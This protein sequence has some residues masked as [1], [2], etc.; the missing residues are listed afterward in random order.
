MPDTPTWIAADGTEHTLDGTN[1][2]K[3]LRGVEGR[4]MPPMTT[5]SDTVAGL[6]GERVRM[7]RAEPRDVAVPAVVSGANWLDRVRTLASLFDPRRGDGVLRWGDRQL[8][9]RY[10]DG[11][12]LDEGEGVPGERQ[13]MVLVF[14]AHDP[15]WLDAAP[16]V[17]LVDVD[18]LAF[19]SADD[20]DPWF[21]W[22]IVAS[23]AAG[24]FTVVNDGDDDAWPVWTVQGPGA[25]MLRLTNDATG[26]LL[27]LTGM[28]L[29]GGEKLIIDTRPGAKTVRGPAGENLWPDMTDDSTLWPIVRG[30]QQ[31]TV[32]LEGAVAGESN[33]RLEWLR[34]W[35]TV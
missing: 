15:M 28:N 20:A 7:A 27:E 12:E 35:L 32:E 25:G 3:V 13:R 18:A 17:E 8:A 16:S 21:G 24:G 19:L 22:S 14:T 4:G 2:V 5:I 11:L 6:D 33:V 29:I 1:G 23:D 34:R 9:C 26:E 31:V 10:S 30:S